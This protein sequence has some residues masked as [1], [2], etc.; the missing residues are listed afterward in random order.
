MSEAINTKPLTLTELATRIRAHLNRFE[1]DKAINAT[2][3][4]SG[5][6][7]YYHANAYRAGRYLGVKYISYQGTLMLDRPTANRYLAWL[8]AGNVG[9]HQKML[10]E[11]ER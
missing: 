8:D 11:E 1:T 6:Q 4:K 5:T 7:P 10:R 9:R 3:L 2:D